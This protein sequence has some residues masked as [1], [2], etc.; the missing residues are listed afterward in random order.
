MPDFNRKSA[1]FVASFYDD[2]SGGAALSAPGVDPYVYGGCNERLNASY[3]RYDRL[4]GKPKDAHRRGRLP[5]VV[6]APKATTLTYRHD[7]HSGGWTAINGDLGRAHYPQSW[8]NGY[9]PLIPRSRM[10]TWMLSGDDN[11]IRF[12]ITDDHTKEQVEAFATAYLACI[13]DGWSDGFVPQAT[14]IQ[15]YRTLLCNVGFPSFPAKTLRAL[16]KTAVGLNGRDINRWNE[17]SNMNRTA[18]WAAIV[19]FL[20]IPLGYKEERLDA[21]FTPPKID[22]RH[23]NG[24]SYLYEPW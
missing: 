17:S 6:N 13:I 24:M 23:G 22:I 14:R 7:Q 21:P 12:E 2:G 5:C 10:N 19:P 18:R 1:R 11:L 4:H 16:I 15:D 20:V 9:L 3:D 8:A